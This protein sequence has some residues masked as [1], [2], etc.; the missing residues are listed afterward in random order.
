VSHKDGRVILSAW[1][2]PVVRMQARA[3]A[4]DAGMAFSRWVERAVMR[5]LARESADVALDKAE[6]RGAR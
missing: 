1:V 6:K 3:A 2:D 4:E 5:S